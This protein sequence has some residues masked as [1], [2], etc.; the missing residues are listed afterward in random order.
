[1][2]NAN[3]PALGADP[4]N[5]TVSGFSSGSSLAG[6]LHMIYSDTIK[7]SGQIAGT[8]YGFGTTSRDSA[9][10][11][12]YLENIAEK[13]AAKKIDDPSNLKNHP[14]YVLGFDRDTYVKPEYGCVA[15][16]LGIFDKYGAKTLHEQK[17]FVH[18]VPTDLPVSDATP[19]SGCED[20]ADVKFFVSNCGFDAAGNL[21]KH[22]MTNLEK[23]P[24]TELKAKSDD[25][26][27]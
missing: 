15:H 23:S 22:L 4:E 16:T 9:T 25:W 27:K 21:L 18:C 2:G 20:K 26:K 13:F 10:T 19:T 17:D 6:T 5:V 7:G 24:L 11:E 14:V 8:P 1:M 12:M 3:L